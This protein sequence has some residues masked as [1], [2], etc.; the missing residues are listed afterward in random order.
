MIKNPVDKP[1]FLIYFCTM[2][3]DNKYLGYFIWIIFFML[4]ATLIFNVTT[5]IKNHNLEIEKQKNE[6]EV[7]SVPQE[8]IEED[9]TI[10]L[11][12]KSNP[13]PIKIVSVIKN[14]DEF[15]DFKWQVFTENGV[16]YYTNET[17]YVGQIAFYINDEDEI[18]NY[19][20]KNKLDPR[21]W[22]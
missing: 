16:M 8:K 11:R 15:I 5:K 12:T 9:T 7:D 6:L 17:V 14:T 13:W 2:K 10:V 3:E 19:H 20:G 22:R 18:V 21:E 1:G 4:M